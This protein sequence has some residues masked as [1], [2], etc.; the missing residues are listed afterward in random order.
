MSGE[1][2]AYILLYNDVAGGY[3]NKLD[4]TFRLGE[5]FHQ[6]ESMNDV[7]VLVKCVDALPE[8][9]KDLWLLRKQSLRPVDKAFEE[10][11]LPV[12]PFA[13]RLELLDNSELCQA[14]KN[15]A[16]GDVV[17]VLPNTSQGHSHSLTDKPAIVKY[18]GPI[19]E[20]ESAGILFGLELLVKYFVLCLSFGEYSNYHL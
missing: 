7:L 8:A 5:I 18:K 6:V 12:Q 19:P 10:Y 9:D 14:L 3:S 11:L 16:K 13:D 20:I 15:L 4:K 1:P 17:F 2:A